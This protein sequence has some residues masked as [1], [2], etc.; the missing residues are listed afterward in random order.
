[1][2]ETGWSEVTLGATSPKTIEAIRHGIYARAHAQLVEVDVDD[3][4]LQ[5][6]IDEA[7]HKVSER[8]RRQHSQTTKA[9]LGRLRALQ[10]VVRKLLYLDDPEQPPEDED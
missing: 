10:G 7:D 1:M 6:R 5:I 9:A 2:L 4:L 3:R 8:L